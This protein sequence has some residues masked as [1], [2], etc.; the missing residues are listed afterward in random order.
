MDWASGISEFAIYNLRLPV[1]ILHLRK[2]R[3]P[4]GN[5]RRFPLRNSGNNFRS[6]LKPMAGGGR[7]RADCLHCLID[8]GSEACAQSLR[9]LRVISLEA[10]DIPRE[11]RVKST[12]IQAQRGIVPQ[13]SPQRVHWLS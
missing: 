4:R 12:L 2:P 11:L 7:G 8:L 9:D 3:Q 5:A 10:L 13:S 6:D 1:A